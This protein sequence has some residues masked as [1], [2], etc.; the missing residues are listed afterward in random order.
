MKES[1]RNREARMRAA[2]RQQ[3]APPALSKYGAKVAAERAALAPR[4]P[5]NG[6]A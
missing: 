6:E 1:R 5:R 2:E 4:K 3:T